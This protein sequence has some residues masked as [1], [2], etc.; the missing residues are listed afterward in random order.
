VE[1]IEPIE[2]GVGASL[3]RGR[4]RRQDP[5]DCTILIISILNFCITNIFNS[6]LPKAN[7][8]ADPRYLDV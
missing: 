7:T 5:E 2:Q 1:S 8:G 4:T 6:V 3:R